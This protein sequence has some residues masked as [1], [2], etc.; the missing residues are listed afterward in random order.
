MRKT[1]SAPKNGWMAPTTPIS[2]RELVGLFG[3][4]AGFGLAATGVAGVAAEPLQTVAR[5]A[6]VA[7][8]K[9]R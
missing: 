8:P 6:D 7:F 2:R 4:A 9:A 1:W 5:A 3:A